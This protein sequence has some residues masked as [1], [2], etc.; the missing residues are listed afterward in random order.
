MPPIAPFPHTVTHTHSLF[1]PNPPLS[2]T[3]SFLPLPH[4]NLCN[5]LQSVHVSE[6]VHPTQCSK[7]CCGNT[8]SFPSHIQLARFNKHSALLMDRLKR[9]AA[10]DAITVSSHARYT[11]KKCTAKSSARNCRSIHNL[12][13]SVA[14]FLLASINSCFAFPHLNPYPPSSP[15]TYAVG[16]RKGQSTCR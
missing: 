1:S 10:L 4:H 5:H 16:F 3:L 6:V 2:H 7:C 11:K 9:K 13:P 8:K 12:P 15:N 14:C